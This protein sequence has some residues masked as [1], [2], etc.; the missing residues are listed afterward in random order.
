MAGTETS[1]LYMY[2]VNDSVFFYAGNSFHLLY[3]F[4]A[5]TGDTITL[6]Y[7]TT[8]D[9]S[10]LK[11]FIDSTDSIIINGETRKLQYVSCGD[12]LVIEFGGIVIEGIG[13]L[14]YMFPRLDLSL[15]GPLRC[16]EDSVIGFF[17]NPYHSENGWNFQDCEQVT[18][19]IP[20]PGFGSDIRLYPNPAT[21]FLEISN[22]DQPAEFTF[23]DIQ[24]RSIKTGV[25]FPDQSINL[26]DIPGGICFLKLQN[27]KLLI[28]KKLIKEL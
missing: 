22:L 4:G 7:Y 13:N 2:S 26:D 9:G 20:E 1:Y 19:G 18:S 8:Y 14:T 15:D 27:S 5:I 3:D 17:I 11:M 10:P 12:G 28:T 24:G 16:Y 21:R 25:I 6:G 23:F